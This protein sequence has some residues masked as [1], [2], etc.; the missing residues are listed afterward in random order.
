MVLAKLV[1]SVGATLA[2][3]GLYRLLEFVIGQLNSP[4]RDLK[5]PPSP[6]WVYGNLK[7]IFDAVSTSRPFL[8]RDN[9]IL[10]WVG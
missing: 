7:Q 5:G 1:L 2:A 4:L 6:S 10:F 3:Y 8:P 9:L